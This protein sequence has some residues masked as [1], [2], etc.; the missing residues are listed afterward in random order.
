MCMCGFTREFFFIADCTSWNIFAIIF[1]QENT[2]RITG[3]REKTVMKYSLKYS[4]GVATH[5]CARTKLAEKNCRWLKMTI[6]TCVHVHNIS[7]MY[8]RV[9]NMIA[10]LTTSFVS[11][12]IIET[13]CSHIICQ[14]SVHVCSIGP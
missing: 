10:I 2:C 9:F 8:R 3:S 5:V 6:C 12:R 11:I 4:M 14:K 13:D 7:F 1:L